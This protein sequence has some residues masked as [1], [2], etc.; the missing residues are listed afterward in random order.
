MFSFCR[1]LILAKAYGIAQLS[2]H[3]LG[4]EFTMLDKMSQRIP[5]FL[6][7]VYVKCPGF[8]DREEVGGW[9]VGAFDSYITPEV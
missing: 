1:S 7:S 6:T 9:G 4:V 8:A 3:C 2:S 5:V